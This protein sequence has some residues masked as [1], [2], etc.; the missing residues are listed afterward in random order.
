MD[1]IGVC[2]AES[3]RGIKH[4][5]VSFWANFRRYIESAKYPSQTTIKWKES[6]W[7]PLGSA[8]QSPFG[9]SVLLSQLPSG[10]KT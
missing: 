1:P 5:Q 10:V 9:G 7:E 2:F 6:K 3:L 8:L 4:F